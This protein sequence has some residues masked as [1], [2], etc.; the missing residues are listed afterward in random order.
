MSNND[1]PTMA[2]TMIENGAFLY[3]ERP[4]N[5]ET[6]RYLWQ[7]VARETMRVMRE[8]E[9]LIMENCNNFFSMD[10]GKRKGN[11]YY[12]KKYVENDHSFDNS[13]LSQGNVK[14]K[15]CTEWTKELHEKFEEAIYQ[16]GD[17]NIF[18]NEIAKKMNVPGLQRMQ[19][20]SHLQKIRQADDEDP[21]STQTDPKSSDGKRSSNKRRRF[22]RMPRSMLAKLKERAHIHS[23]NSEMEGRVTES[24]DGEG[25][26]HKPSRF[27]SMPKIMEANS[28]DRVD[29]HGSRFEMQ[30]VAN[31]T[32]MANQPS[33]EQEDIF[34]N[35]EAFLINPKINI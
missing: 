18:P 7:H 30:A 9:R 27:G 24:S 17:G 19:I 23:S 26:S 29:D 4:A 34:N 12:N 14:R 3:I 13:M 6:L 28:I 21:E 31:E 8:R 33:Y 35:L 11:D 5:P 25:A 1:N 2:V 32:G 20:A 22:G 16:L 15:M 10:K